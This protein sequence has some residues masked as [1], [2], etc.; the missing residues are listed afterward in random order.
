MVT[1]FTRI[2]MTPQKCSFAMTALLPNQW[3]APRPRQRPSPLPR[4]LWK[5][6][7]SSHRFSSLLYNSLSLTLYSESSANH[8]YFIIWILYCLV[9]INEYILIIIDII[10]KKLKKKIYGNPISFLSLN[11]HSQQPANNNQPATASTNPD[12]PRQL[13]DNVLQGMWW[14]WP[15]PGSIRFHATNVL[16]GLRGREGEE[17]SRADAED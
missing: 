1:A 5:R 11:K 8:I 2:P 16:P 17:V 7:S 4:T 10:K 3:S 6:N 12:E 9:L 14:Y 15:S 13:H